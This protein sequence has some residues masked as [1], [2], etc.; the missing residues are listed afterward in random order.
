[1]LS[2][3]QGRP[4]LEKWSAYLLLWMVTFVFISPAT[5]LD[6]FV[7]GWHERLLAISEL[8]FVPTPIDITTKYGPHPAVKLTHT[9]P[10]GVWALCAASQLTP[11]LRTSRPTL[12]RW[13]GRVMLLGSAPLMT[14][15][16]VL[17]ERRGLVTAFQFDGTEQLDEAGERVKVPPSPSGLLVLRLLMVWF[18]WTALA[19]VAA[20]RS[21]RYDKHATWAVRHI[22]SGIWVVVQR[23]LLSI[24][25]MAA[26][27]AGVTWS[28]KARHDLF[29]AAATV[30]IVSSLVAG[31]VYV[32]TARS[33][34]RKP[35]VEGQGGAV[36]GAVEGKGKAE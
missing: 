14:A 16:Y 24:V 9:L 12:H 5:W 7:P 4:Q 22:A 17:M 8:P 27:A 15:G 11:S 26:A 23:L 36:A 10:S 2:K 21:R 3:P 1:M 18:M 29:A 28:V 13:A 33:Y 25:A 6:G 19:A 34:L 20:A 30:S 31:E 35:G 32:R